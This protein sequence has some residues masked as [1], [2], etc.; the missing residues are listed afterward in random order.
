LRHPHWDTTIVFLED[1]IGSDVFRRRASS[2]PFADATYSFEDAVRLSEQASAEF[3][4]WSH[5]ECI[6]MK[7][8]LTAMDH[9]HTGR[10][11]LAEFYG[12][13]DAKTQAFTEKHQFPEEFGAWQ[14][15]EPLEQLQYSG[16][17][18]ESSAWLGPQVM[19]PNYINGWFNCITSAPY[20]Q[21]C[22]LNEC[23]QVF[24]HL[25]SQ[26]AAPSASSSEI[27]SALEHQLERNISALHRERLDEIA[28]VNDGQIPIYGRLF[29]RWIHF[30]Y[31]QECAYPHAAG[32]V[33][34]MTVQ[35]LKS[36]KEVGATVE[37]IAHHKASVF[38]HRAASPDAG[39]LMWSLDEALLE[40]STPSD[41]AASPMRAL[42]HIVPQISMA[43]GF[44][45]IML[46]TLM[47]TF[48]SDAKSKPVE[49]DV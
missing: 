39:A 12:Y 6:E 26:I 2:N 32:V 17:L 38:A 21:I 13:T 45:S 4:S 34:P 31:P 40:S 41:L 5:H 43:V 49:Y 29:A 20:Y 44:L 24:Q 18:D 10:V 23:D 47:Q 15:L 48:R 16:A 30:V 7:D 36:E 37:D 33:K 8:M 35:E 9:H 14:F 19:I 27:I 3:G 25:E 42:L 28:R 1:N 46:K 11:K 22:C